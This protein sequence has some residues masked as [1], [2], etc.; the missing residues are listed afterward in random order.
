M[1]HTAIYQCF[2]LICR[3]HIIYKEVSAENIYKLKI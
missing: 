1:E 2:T 3:F